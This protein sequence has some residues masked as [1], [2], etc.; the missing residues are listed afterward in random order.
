MKN[1]RPISL[2]C[3]V[4]KLISGVIAERI[5]PCLDKI[6]SKSQTGFI[7]GRYIGESIRTIY[8]L[9]HLTEKKKIPGLVMLIDFEKAFDSVSWK[10]LYSTL[11][12][13]GFDEAFISWIKLFNNNITAFVLQCGVLSDPIHIGR[14][15]RQGDPISPYLF[16]LVAE[17]LNI[18]IENNVDI[19]GICVGAY[20]FKMTQFADDTTILL[21]GSHKSLQTALN[22]LELFGSLSGLKMNTEKTKMVWIGSRKHCREKLNISADLQWGDEEFSFLGINFSVNLDTI[23]ELNFDIAMNKAKQLLN[24]WNSRYLTPIGRITVIKTMVLSKFNHLFMSIVTPPKILDELNKLFF[25]YLWGGKTHKVKQKSV[26]ADYLKGGLR[27]VNIYNFE[28]S[29]KLVWMKNILSKS[30]S[31]WNLLLQES[32]KNLKQMIYIG[33]EWFQKH[34]KDVNPFWY[35]VFENWILFCRN[36]TVKSGKDLLSSSLWCNRQISSDNIFYVNWFKK[37]ITVLADLLNSS[38]NFLDPGELKIKYN[39]KFN[40]LN[41]YTVKHLVTQFMKNNRLLLKEKLERPHVPFH[42]NVLLNFEKGSK[43]FYSGLSYYGYENPNNENKWSLVLNTQLHNDFWKIAY[44]ICFK[45]ILDNSYIWFQYR[46]LHRI[47]G[48]KYYLYKLKLSESFLCGI[49][50]QQQESIYHLFAG[51]EK[52]LDF[53]KNIT[54]WFELKLSIKVKFSDIELIFGYQNYDQNFWP[55]NFILLI[56]RQY[57]FHCSK[58]SHDINIYNL[59]KLVEEKYVEQYT[60]SKIKDTVHIFNR[61]W[62][63]WKLLFES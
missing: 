7:K 56:A 38:G 20:S 55:L 57:I 29:L 1:W 25:F 3:A 6:I 11:A 27:M 63:H 39:L 2:L 22:T 26:C 44:K 45:T 23:P 18:L 14:G 4:Y 47:L 13:F 28:K 53:W 49:C 31:P 35:D 15:C 51:C 62:S 24:C 33:P 8:D 9:M 59:Q 5:K 52:V 30:K 58:Y 41:Y 40:I 61:N 16:L 10:F 17:V 50:G 60:L 46:I 48:T 43:N 12:L 32:C 37:G 42:I 21:D 54:I 34:R 36:Q 19:K